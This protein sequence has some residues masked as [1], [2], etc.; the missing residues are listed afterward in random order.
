MKK[1]V[2]VL[3]IAV[4][5]IPC[6]SF[7]VNPGASTENAFFR[8][9]YIR[10]TASGPLGTTGCTYTAAVGVIFD[11]DEGTGNVTIIQVSPPSITVNCS[12]IARTVNT[13]ISNLEM[14]DADAHCID[15]QFTKTGDVDVDA[16]LSDKNF[17]GQIKSEINTQVDAQKH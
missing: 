1:I 16:L 7:T 5:T 11:W 3:L 15:I 6:F 12:N 2:F 14:D 17:L 8:R 9:F 4:V 13:T 10:L